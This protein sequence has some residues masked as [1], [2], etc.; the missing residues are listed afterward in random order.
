VTGHHTAFE[1]FFGALFDGVPVLAR[2]RATHD[3][4][5]EHKAGSRFAGLDR[6]NDVAVLTAATGLTHE[7]AL[8]LGGLANGLAVRHHRAA[9][10]GLYVELAEH[11]IHEDF[12]VQ[13]A[14]ARDD[15]LAR[16]VVYAHVEGRIFFAELLKGLGQL[17]LVGL[18]L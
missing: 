1:R 9:D 16:L 13:L 3:L 11:A 10:T 12:Q 7:A 2:H 4:A 18:R 5:F 15:R 8:G 17:V 6:E 14:H